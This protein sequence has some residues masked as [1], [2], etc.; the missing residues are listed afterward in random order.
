[1]RPAS[2]ILLALA[3]LGLLWLA[4]PASERRVEAA[5]PELV[6]VAGSNTATSVLDAPASPSGSLAARATPG[7]VLGPFPAEDAGGPIPGG[8]GRLQGRV[9]S[10]Q[11]APLVL[12]R[13]LGVGDDD[14]PGVPLDADPAL[15]VD[16]GLRVRTAKP[17]EDG[18]F[19]L[20]LQ[21]GMA[22]IAVR[23]RGAVP[24]HGTSFS[25]RSG[26]VRDL[27]DIVLRAGCRLEGFVRDSVGDPAVGVPILLDY[28]CVRRPS[29][30]V[31]PGR[32]TLVATSDA[33]GEFVVDELGEG[34]WL[35]RTAAAR[36]LNTEASG[37]INRAGGERRA[38]L[39]LGS[40]SSIAGVVRAQR[41]KLPE[42]L[43]VRARLAPPASDDEHSSLRQLHWGSDPDPAPPARS[44]DWPDADLQ[45]DHVAVVRADG[46]FQLEGLLRDAPYRLHPSLPRIGRGDLSLSWSGPAILQGGGAEAEWTLDEAVAT[47]RCR[48]VSAADGRPLRQAH[49]WIGQDG[50]WEA[51]GDGE[52]DVVP[53]WTDGL[54]EWAGVWVGESGAK[55]SFRV[56]APSHEDHAWDDLELEPG[57]TLDLGE[58][59]LARGAQLELLLLRADTH[60]PVPGL[61]V[62]MVPA[63]RGGAAEEVDH[64][65]E[66]DEANE[67]IPPGIPGRRS[68]SDSTGLVRFPAMPGADVVL[69]GQFER[70]KSIKVEHRFEPGA[71]LRLEWLLQPITTLEVVVVDA[72]GRGVEGCTV[73]VAEVEANPRDESSCHTVTTDWRGLAVF[74][75]LTPGLHRARIERTG[76]SRGFHWDDCDH[77][78]PIE[79][80]EWREVRVESDR[81]S[82]LQMQDYERAA[83]IGELRLDGHP[84]AYAKVMLAPWDPERGQ[85]WCEWSDDG[86][87]LQATADVAGVFALERVP[88]GKWR[89]YATALGVVH[90][91]EA[92]VVVD[93][94]SNRVDMDWTTST[95]SGRVFDSAGRPL[96]R[97]RVRVF[98]DEL[99]G[100]EHDL[101]AEPWSDIEIEGL[102]ANTL[103]VDASGEWD[104]LWGL[105]SNAVVT[106]SEGRWCLR[107]VRSEARL[108]LE[109]EHRWH[110]SVLERGIVVPRGET[111]EGVD[112]RMEPGGDLLLSP[113]GSALSRG[114]FRA[115]AS[116]ERDGRDE[117]GHVLWT[118]RSARLHSKLPVG[119]WNLRLEWVVR[120]KDSRVVASGSLE[121][122]VRI[123]Q[124]AR[125]ILEIKAE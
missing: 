89:L 78:P 115:W 29:P 93:P 30:L 77:S 45:R 43:V 124:H 10:E 31:L 80:T 90:A 4:R 117:E 39:A 65:G 102:Q 34:P 104:E 32:G 99:D 86:D 83:V 23:A 59:R 125:E 61:Q 87:V 2:R 1:M 37:V 42:G 40:G 56:G 111:L 54:V 21:A 113:S 67:F 107:G 48:V 92:L 50:S 94:G 57:E 5:F 24:F 74:P 49:A 7:E 76:D 112:V 96:A 62:H 55:V 13:V 91:Q 95:L 72:S 98:R 35:L 17:A 81:V 106:D 51:W 108:V 6:E 26:E 14:G 27:G 75:S 44:S 123:A 9:L 101:L 70:F 109:F 41:G 52:D 18:R 53:D 25:L 69:E 58:V 79:A 103:L 105:E 28:A 97:A 121:R 33:R 60:E 118:N 122:K 47:V 20:D 38:W 63:E 71:D 68:V 110:A 36:E 114:D 22:R 46:S 85:V 8:C 66:A 64:E 73:A 116:L 100:V 3:S 15:L 12:A 19:V 119:E 88:L 84:M 16:L 82:R 120:S 11:G